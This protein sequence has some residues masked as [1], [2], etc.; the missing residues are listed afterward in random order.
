[1]GYNYDRYQRAWV[2]EGVLAVGVVYRKV[3]VWVTSVVSRAAKILAVVVNSHSGS[4]FA[5][6]RKIGVGKG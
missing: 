2:V 6:M 5:N 1:M 3:L 4:V